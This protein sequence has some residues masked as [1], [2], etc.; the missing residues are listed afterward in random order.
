MKSYSSVEEVSVDINNMLLNINTN[1]RAF[2]L[3]KLTVN[4]HGEQQLEIAGSWNWLRVD[5]LTRRSAPLADLV[6]SSVNA[7]INPETAKL[8]N[9]VDRI[10]LKRGSW[11]MIFLFSCVKRLLKTCYICLW[12][13]VETMT[14]WWSVIILMLLLGSKHV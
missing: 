5:A 3:D 4:Q 2:S 10:H 14:H 8:Y 9:V 12:A 13:G 11:L 6:S 1:E 7:V